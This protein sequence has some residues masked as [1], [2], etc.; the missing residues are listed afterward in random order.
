VCAR[1]RLRSLTAEAI[2]TGVS[3]SR[4][5]EGLEVSSAGTAFDADLLEGA[6][7]IFEAPARL[8]FKKRPLC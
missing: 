4:G 1:N 5:V 7:A 8:D 2:F 6:D 3:K